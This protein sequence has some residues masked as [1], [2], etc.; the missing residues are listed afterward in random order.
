MRRKQKEEELAKKRE[1]QTQALEP[2]PA[3]EPSPAQEL[4]PEPAPIEIESTVSE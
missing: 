4:A 3:Q 2:E 1:V